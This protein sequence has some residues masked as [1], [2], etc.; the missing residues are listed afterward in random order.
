MSSVPALAV[1]NRFIELAHEQGDSC[2]NMKLQKLVYFA[3]GLHLALGKGPLIS[4]QF[5]AW[6]YGPVVPELYQKF[7]GYFAGP[8]PIDHPYSGISAKLSPFSDALVRKT[9]ALFGRFSATRLSEISHEKGSAWEECYAAG[10]GSAIIRNDRIAA[11]F[12]KRFVKRAS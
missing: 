6:R 2:S 11:Y 9:Y 3:H 5:E 7:K 12:Q 10:T 8:I 1:A 4:E